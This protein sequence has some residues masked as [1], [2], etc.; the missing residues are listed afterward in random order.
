MYRAVSSWCHPCSVA[1]SGLMQKPLYSVLLHFFVLRIPQ[2]CHGMTRSKKAYTALAVV[3]GP[4]RAAFLDPPL[5]VFALLVSDRGHE[6][7]VELSLKWRIAY[8][9]LLYIAIPTGV[10][11]AIAEKDQDFIML[12]FW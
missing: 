6:G 12:R 5:N 11:G 1:L 4:Q 9:R 3:V 7:A 10:P 2:G 8:N